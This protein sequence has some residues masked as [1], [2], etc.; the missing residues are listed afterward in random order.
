ML[1]KYRVHGYDGNVYINQEKEEYS[2]LQK[3]LVPKS[4][5][6]RRASKKIRG[7]RASKKIREGR[8]KRR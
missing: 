7:G 1:A 6:G 8:A 5:G 4:I 3:I 2:R